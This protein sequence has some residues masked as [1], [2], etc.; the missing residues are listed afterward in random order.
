MIGILTSFSSTHIGIA[1][2]LK[3]TREDIANVKAADKAYIALPYRF[4][5][6]IFLNIVI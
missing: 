4:D 5:S 1:Y 6:P 3:K 2:G